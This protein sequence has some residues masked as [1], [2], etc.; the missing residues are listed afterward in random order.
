MLL[1]YRPLTE[2]EIQVTNSYGNNN[3]EK[4]KSTNLGSSLTGQTLDY[5]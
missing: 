2:K 4:L 1:H 5:M 3:S